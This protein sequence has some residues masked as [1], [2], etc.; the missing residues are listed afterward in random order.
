MEL[1]KPS[2]GNA[3]FKP[4]TATFMQPELLAHPPVPCAK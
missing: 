3:K 4:L 2:N 1:M